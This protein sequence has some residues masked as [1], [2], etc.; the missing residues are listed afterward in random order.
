MLEMFK[1]ALP[2][3]EKVAPYV[4]QALRGTIPGNVISL[5]ATVF[6]SDPENPA[7]IATAM[8]NDPDLE[9]KL[10][11]CDSHIKTC[12]VETYN[13][14]PHCI[15][16]TINNPNLQWNLTISSRHD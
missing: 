12:D 3:I 15:C 8:S 2:L 7:A 13:D 4:A 16:E 14:F 10:K 1:D 11:A 6:L 5:L 9:R